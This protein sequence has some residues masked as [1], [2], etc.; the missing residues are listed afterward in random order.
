MD[1]SLNAKRH[2]HQKHTQKTAQHACEVQV[3][4]RDQVKQAVRF[5]QWGERSHV[6]VHDAVEHG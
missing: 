2:V 6:G 5:D 1:S 4:D 3:I